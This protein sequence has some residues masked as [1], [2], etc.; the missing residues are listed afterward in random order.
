MGKII[1]AKKFKN[2]VKHED[3]KDSF[4]KPVNEAVS[5]IK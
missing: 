4:T 2:I 5:I 1:F 3:I